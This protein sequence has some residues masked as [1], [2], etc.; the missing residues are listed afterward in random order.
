MRRLVGLLA[1]VLAIG[2]A[3]GGGGDGKTAEAPPDTAKA[4]DG[5]TST[6]AAER[7][8][9][10]DV[11]L[12]SPCVPA[13]S[14][15]SIMFTSVEGAGIAFNSHYADGKDGTYKDFYGGNL[16]GKT[17]A[18]G[19][20]KATW[21]IAENAPSGP[22]RVTYK[23]AQLGYTVAESEISFRVVPPGTACN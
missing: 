23:A 15:Q 5:S 1:V 2:G 19:T 7:T 21:K 13:G 22:V 14:E 8:L 12:G 6:T 9:P 10:L 16:G 18:D 4:P 11:S 17:E 3:C 20:W